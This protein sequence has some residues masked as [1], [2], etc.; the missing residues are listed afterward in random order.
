MKII[1]TDEFQ[2][3]T[4]VFP[5]K[6]M[7]PFALYEWLQN[8]EFKED[9]VIVTCNDYV[10]KEIN[11]KIMKGEISTNGM[12]SISK[13]DRKVEIDAKYGLDI[14]SIDGLIHHQNQVAN[15]VYYRTGEDDESWKDIKPLP[16]RWRK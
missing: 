12:E 13:W 1:F 4:Y 14:K 11:I 15:A 3:G 2:K 10:I 5:E 6:T 16:N 9:D 8:V 7:N